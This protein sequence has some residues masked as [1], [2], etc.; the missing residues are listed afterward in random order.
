MNDFTRPTAY[1]GQSSTVSRMQQQYW[2]TKQAFFRKIGR[3]EDDCIIASDA[4]LDAKLELFGAIQE[5]CTNL[6]RVLENY[7]DRILALSQEENALGRFLKECGKQDKT[8]AGKM[9]GAT[10]KTMSYSAQQRLTLRVPLV[11]LYQEVET[12]QFRAIADTLATV[13]KM[14][15]SRTDYRGALLWMKDI[16]QQLD[17]DTYKQLEKFRK[18]QG[19]VKRTKMQ[20]EKLKLD[21]LQKVDLLAA[22]RCNMFSHVL[23]T[24]QNAL[25]SFWEKTSSTMTNVAESF[26]GYQHYDFIVVKELQEPS[27]K[28][29]E[30][31]GNGE[32]KASKEDGD[33]DRYS[34]TTESGTENHKMLFFESEYHDDEGKRD[35]RAKDKKRK[36]K[37]KPPRRDGVAGPGGVDSKEGPRLDADTKSQS[38]LDDVPLLSLDESTSEERPHFASDAL[39]DAGKLPLWREDLLTH[40]PEI[41]DLEKDDMTLLSEILASSE[42]V[43]PAAFEAGA[44]ED[45]FAQQWQTAFGHLPPSPQKSLSFGGSLL[46]KPEL[47][48]N[49]PATTATTP[50][51]AGDAPSQFLPSQL[52][53]LE[54]GIGALE[55]KGMPAEALVQSLEPIKPAAV[56]TQKAQPI[57]GPM[58]RPNLKKDKRDMSAWFNLFADLDPL[59]N[60]DA[61]GKKSTEEDRNC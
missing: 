36:K 61:I 16:S 21:T 13:E 19:H 8:R 18:V 25:L 52:L 38:S 49:P 7:Q 58:S 41:S 31:M 33:K 28:L 29:A 10:G 35:A 4:E 56:T 11:R 40:N 6:L 55:S 15:R 50:Q 27:R 59:A 17:P 60:P 26:K 23:A 43:Y 34:K 44:P 32:E 39:R 5:S 14:E 42:S 48:A 3:K 2:T 24:Y 12:Y 37:E 30:E 9:M 46:T 57:P 47:L 20:F 53:D 1:Y 45:S 51:P 54:D 22:S